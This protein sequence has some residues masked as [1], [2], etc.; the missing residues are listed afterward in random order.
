MQYE[1]QHA[2]PMV[3]E[4]VAKILGAPKSVDSLFAT[5]SDGDADVFVRVHPLRPDRVEYLFYGRVSVLYAENPALAPLV[6]PLERHVRR[7]FVQAQ[8]FA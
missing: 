2:F 7:V 3:V 4:E 8:A 6:E 1:V 5:F